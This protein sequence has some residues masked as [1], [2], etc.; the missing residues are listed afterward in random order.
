[1][2]NFY[3]IFRQFI[4]QIHK[5]YMDFLY[6]FIQTFSN[7]SIKIN[8]KLVMRSLWLTFVLAYLIRVIYVHMS[9]IKNYFLITNIVK[10]IFQVKIK[11]MFPFVIK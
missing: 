10:I 1:M 11:K 3:N 6:I 8:Q 4:I 7:Q 9:K 5:I 2:K